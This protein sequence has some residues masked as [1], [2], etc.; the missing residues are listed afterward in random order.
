MPNQ[1]MEQ[2]TSQSVMT[3]AYEWLCKKR[4]DYSANSDIWD[5]RRNWTEFQ[6]QLQQQ[7]LSGDFRFSPQR[8]HRFTDET[9]AVW[10]AVD[11]L[12]LKCV[13]IVLTPLLAPELS[14]RCF[15]VKGHGGLKAAVRETDA[16]LKEH[17]HIYPLSKW[18][19]NWRLIFHS[20]VFPVG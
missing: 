7:L 11:S 16:A 20:D 1:L 10:A 5:L 19:V 12:V 6:P 9:K 13:A 18:L 8:Q 15:N 2:I 4:I 14:S 17:S 3:K